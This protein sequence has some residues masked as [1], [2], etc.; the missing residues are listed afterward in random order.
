MLESQNSN[1]PKI[2][3]SG[4]VVKGKTHYKLGLSQEI[5]VKY[6]DS[7]YLIGNDGSIYN[8]KRNIFLQQRES[9]SGFLT[10]R[11][12]YLEKDD[13]S[14]RTLKEVS[15]LVAEC[16]VIIPENMHGMKLITKHIDNNKLNNNYRNLKWITYIEQGKINNLLDSC[17]EGHKKMR[18]K[19]GT[20]V[21]SYD[22]DGTFVAKYDS[23][24]DSLKKMN[25]NT[26][27]KNSIIISLNKNNKTAFGYYW[28]SLTQNE[29]P[30][31]KIQVLYSKPNGKL[32]IKTISADGEHAIIY[33]SV[34]D[35]MSTLH[36][37][38]QKIEKLK[39]TN[40]IYK[41][42]TFWSELD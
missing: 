23:I 24:R 21:A 17:I 37:D 41:G 16:F 42:Y 14:Y 26:N 34:K 20:I 3:I 7:D 30:P 35:C 13:L 11:L 40:N 9:A 29:T 6:L 18:E 31:A 19:L 28:I 27:S 38:R 39:N 1:K 25:R 22:L 2:S 8:L 4:H 5:F 12:R 36:I 10:V 32:P 15:R 33:S